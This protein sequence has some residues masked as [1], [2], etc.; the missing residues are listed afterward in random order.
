MIARG[1]SRETVRRKGVTPISTNIQGQDD[2]DKIL[3]MI[4]AS[5]EL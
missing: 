5:S 2:D 1:L 3:D 4:M